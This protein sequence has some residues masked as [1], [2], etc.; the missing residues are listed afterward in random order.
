MTSIDDG[1]VNE[2]EESKPRKPED[3]DEKDEEK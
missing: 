3:D 1:S 2:C